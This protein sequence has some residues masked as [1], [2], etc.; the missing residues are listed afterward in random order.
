MDAQANYCNYARLFE[1][2]AADM[3]REYV[4]QEP[5]VVRIAQAKVRLIDQYFQWRVQVPKS[6]RN[7]IGEDGHICIFHVFERA[8]QQ[9]K[10]VELTLSP[11]PIIVQ[12]PPPPRALTEIGGIYLGE[13]VGTEE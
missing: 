7:R 1:R 5:D 3:L 4:H 11:P 2:W 8:Y 10:M 6:H 9:I 12:P 13:V